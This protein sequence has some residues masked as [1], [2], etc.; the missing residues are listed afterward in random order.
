MQN[1]APHD[2]YN[3]AVQVQSIESSY[4]S[5]ASY[6]NYPKS[7]NVPEASTDGRIVSIAE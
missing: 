4:A 6:A 3:V 5:Y 2:Y 1:N 7:F